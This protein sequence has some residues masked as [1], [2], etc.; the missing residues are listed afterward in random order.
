MCEVNIKDKSIY[1]IMKAMEEIKE[2][3]VNRKIYVKQRIDE[4]DERINFI[5]EKLDNKDSK[6]TFMELSPLWDEKENLYQERKALLLEKK[7]FKKIDFNNE[8][9]YNMLGYK[10]KGYS[11]MLENLG[12]NKDGIE[13]DN[14]DIAN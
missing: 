6:L 8:L 14:M 11:N 10:I 12:L 7:L 1:K 4:L 13:L 9:S 5:Q 2:D 3:I